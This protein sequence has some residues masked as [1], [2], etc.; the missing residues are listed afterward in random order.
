M[1]N[2]RKKRGYKLVYKKELRVVRDYFINEEE[3]LDYY[4]NSSDPTYEYYK[5]KQVL[6]LVD[7]KEISYFETAL[8]LLR[9][10][11]KLSFLFWQDFQKFISEWVLFKGWASSLIKLYRN[12][13]TSI[14][15]TK[16][17]KI[18]GPIKCI[19]IIKRYSL[20]RVVGVKIVREL[21]YLISKSKATKGVIV[22]T[23]RLSNEA[24]RLIEENCF[25]M[26]YIDN[27]MI[28]NDLL[29][30]GNV[31]EDVDDLPL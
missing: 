3:N 18:L 8:N 23:S 9:R 6:E 25:T 11:K 14:I 20:N 1:K 29:S 15:T 16:Q 21:G 27:G 5:F 19:W 31:S 12:E 2:K 30:P 26:N 17:D 24:M 28:E 10:G 13:G 7:T 22:T 4:Q